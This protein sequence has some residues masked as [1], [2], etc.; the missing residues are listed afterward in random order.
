MGK[1]LAFCSQTASGTGS[2]SA[3]NILYHEDVLWRKN[4]SYMVQ[5]F[6]ASASFSAFTVQSRWVAAIRSTSWDHSMNHMNPMPGWNLPL[7]WGYWFSSGSQRGKLNSSSLSEFLHVSAIPSLKVQRKPESY[8]WT[9]LTIKI[10]G[11]ERS[12]LRLSVLTCAHS[13]SLCSSLL[14][15][16]LI[17]KTVKQL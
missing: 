16:C 10:A 17:I 7:F 4:L 12:V 6:S 5:G 15:C 11:P 3:I 8:K 1:L 9:L 13:Q 2:I 14:C